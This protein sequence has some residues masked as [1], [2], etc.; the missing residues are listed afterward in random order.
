MVS[1]VQ[2]FLNG[3]HAI[4]IFHDIF[5]A[6]EIG[7]CT[8]C[9]HQIIIGY[10]TMIGM[11]SIMGTIYMGYLSHKQLYIPVVADMRYHL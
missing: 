5:H 11:Y 2:C 9:H 6:K 10:I 3:L 8:S 7:F 4:G 1:D